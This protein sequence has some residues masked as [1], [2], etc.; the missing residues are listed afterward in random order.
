MHA[1]I[2]TVVAVR[3]RPWD[4]PFRKL[5]FLK[6]TIS[7]YPTDILSGDAIKFHI[8]RRLANDANTYYKVSR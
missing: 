2:L 5:K 1:H 6:W 4:R 8:Y 7:A 3:L